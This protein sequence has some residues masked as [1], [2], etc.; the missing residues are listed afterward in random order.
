MKYTEKW[1]WGKQT[2]VLS[3]TY[4]SGDSY[5][6]AVYISSCPWMRDYRKRI[7]AIDTQEKAAQAIRDYWHMVA[8]E[9][10]NGEGI[11]IIR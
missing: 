8:R 2:K 11:K 4:A 6:T 3:T 1:A 10:C 9:W 5:R 7:R